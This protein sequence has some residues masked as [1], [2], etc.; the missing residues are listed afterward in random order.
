MASTPWTRSSSSRIALHSRPME[1]CW[2]AISATCASA[3]SIWPRASSPRSPERAQRLAERPARD[4]FRSRWQSVSCVA[5]RQRDHAA[6]P[7]DQT[8]SKLPV[9]VSGP[10]GI[11]YSPDGSLFI[12]DTESH[13]ILRF[14]LKSQTAAVA[15]APATRKRA[16]WRSAEVQPLP[17]AWNFCGE[18]RRGVY[19]R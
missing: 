8:W 19:R 7:C 9:Q 4:R 12:A 2:S 15:V 16:G 10:K 6:R 14:D 18:G 13:R 1:R 11:S 5:R 17:S 3:G